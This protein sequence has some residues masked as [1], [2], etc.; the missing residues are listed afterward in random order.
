MVGV[1]DDDDDVIRLRETAPVDVV[2]ILI[3]AVA[4]GEENEETSAV[5]PTDKRH[6][7]CRHRI[8]E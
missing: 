1:D 7:R 8:V 3:F 6:T 2:A 4:A 5:G